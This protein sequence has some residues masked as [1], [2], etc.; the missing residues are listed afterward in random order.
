[1]C[2]YIMIPSLK[3]GHKELISQVLQKTYPNLHHII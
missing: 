1:M 2:S 3:K